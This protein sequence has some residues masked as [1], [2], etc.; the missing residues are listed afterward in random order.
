MPTGNPSPN[1]HQIQ[2]VG[3]LFFPVQKSFDRVA[4][5]IIPTVRSSL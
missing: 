3:K 2:S 5:Q 4:A 1:W